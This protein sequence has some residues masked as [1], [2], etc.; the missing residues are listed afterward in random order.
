[1]EELI[2]ILQ[3]LQ[4]GKLDDT[5]AL[6]AL[7]DEHIKQPMIELAEEQVDTPEK[8]EKLAL[9]VMVLVFALR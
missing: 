3:D 1:M 9:I 7:I 5:S 8:R 6:D 2:R 4:D